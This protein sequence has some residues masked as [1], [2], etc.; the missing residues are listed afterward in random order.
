MTRCYAKANDNFSGGLKHH[1]VPCQLDGLEMVPLN[2][3]SLQCHDNES[4]APQ[5][6]CEQVAVSREQMQVSSDSASSKNSES[7]TRPELPA[8][9]YSKGEPEAQ[10]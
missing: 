3:G 10:E 2:Y 7:G 8:T 5:V 9:S 1:L 4:P 6:M